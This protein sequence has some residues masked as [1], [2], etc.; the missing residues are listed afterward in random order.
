MR[1]LIK[2]VLF[3]AVGFIISGAIIVWV[4]DKMAQPGPYSFST[5]DDDY[6]IPLATMGVLIT[7]DSNPQTSEY[8]YISKI[9]KTELSQILIRRPLNLPERFFKVCIRELL[10]EPGLDEP[11]ITVSL[12]GQPMCWVRISRLGTPEQMRGFA[13]FS[14]ELIFRRLQELSDDEGSG[15][16]PAERP[17]RVKL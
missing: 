17:K 15:K 9:F 11:V 13:H 3:L 7:Y 8:K 12:D 5:A 6:R 10:K 14:S 2:A 4:S 1:R 16:L